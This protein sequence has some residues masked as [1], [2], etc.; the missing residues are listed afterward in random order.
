MPRTHPLVL[1]NFLIS[2]VKSSPPHWADLIM[3]HNGRADSAGG[4]QGERM[5]DVREYA[6]ESILF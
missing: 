1:R 6:T 5:P 4:Y 3:V 2:P